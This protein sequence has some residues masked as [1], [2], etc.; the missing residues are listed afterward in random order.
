[1]T[2]ARRRRERIR[3]LERRQRHLASRIRSHPNWTGLSYDR[4]ELAAVSWALQIVRA[5]D[6]SDVLDELEQ[7]AVPMELAR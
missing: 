7:V 6:R 3:V 5:A 2:S 1:M 4:A